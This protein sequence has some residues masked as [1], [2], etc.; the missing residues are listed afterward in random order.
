[1][2][3]SAVVFDLDGVLRRWDPRIVAEAESTHGLAPG[4]LT[5]VAFEPDRLSAAVTGQLTDEQWRAG[6]VAVLAQRYGAQAAGAVAQ[7]SAAV[8][9]VDRAVLAL[10]RE[11]RRRCRVVLLSNATTRLCLDLARLGLQHELDEVFSSAELGV[12]KPDPRVF[13]EVCRRLGVDPPDCALV[14]DTPGHVLAAEEVGMVGHRYTS[15]D[16]LLRFLHGVR[17]SSPAAGRD[18][19]AQLDQ[20]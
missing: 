9:E 8:G 14:D 10:V 4:A 12:A 16:A 7:W 18:G 19:P 3:V 13:H 17:C 6:I 5:A 2:V 11:Q 20:R 1:M 15:P